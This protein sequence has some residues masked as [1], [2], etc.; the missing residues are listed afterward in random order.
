MALLFTLHTQTYQS[1]IYSFQSFCIILFRYFLYRIRFFMRNSMVWK[2]RCWCADV[3][4]ST[5]M[6]SNKTHKTL[7]MHAN[8]TVC[9]CMCKMCRFSW[10]KQ[11]TKMFIS[12]LWYKQKFI[13]KT[14]TDVFLYCRKFLTISFRKTGFGQLWKLAKFFNWPSIDFILRTRVRAFVTV[15][16]CDW[17]RYIHSK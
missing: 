13:L 2:T 10:R 6:N 14:E 17:I 1:Y 9:G 16:R 3:Y 15:C 12:I 7:I 4:A 11:T 5:E 8:K